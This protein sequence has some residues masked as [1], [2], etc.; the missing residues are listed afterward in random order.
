MQA[1]HRWQLQ[2]RRVLQLHAYQTNLKEFQEG[3]IYQNVYRAPRIPD[4]KEI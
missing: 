4:Q 2:K 3:T 1:V